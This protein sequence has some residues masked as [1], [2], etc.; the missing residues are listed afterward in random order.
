MRPSTV[1]PLAAASLAALSLPAQEN[2]KLDLKVLFAGVA[3]HAR[4]EQW[5]QFLARHTRDVRVLDVQAFTEADAEGA[6]VVILDCPD[7]ILRD[8][9]GRPTRVAVPMPKQLTA[10]FAR[11]TIVVG[12]MAMV[13]DR[14]QLKSNWL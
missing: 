13:T 3:G 2:E 8:G 9:N 4:T 11:P 7:P 12:G 6:D 5:Q 10:G 1:L 14:L